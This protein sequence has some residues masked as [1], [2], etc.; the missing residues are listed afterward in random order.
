MSAVSALTNCGGFPKAFSAG[1]LSAAGL[2]ADRSRAVA[3]RDRLLEE[4]PHD[5]HAEC[6]I[7]AIWRQG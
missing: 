1:D 4:Y 5:A 6:A 3:I 7:W 2:I